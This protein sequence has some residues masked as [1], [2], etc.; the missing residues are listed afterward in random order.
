[1]SVSIKKLQLFEATARLGKLTKAASELALSQSA[2]SQALK[3]LEQSLGYAL[4]ERVG[5]DLLIT[6]NGLKSLPKVRQIAGLLDSIKLTNLN[7][8]SGTLR[9]VASA[10]IA[11]YL[12]PKLIAK[13]IKTYPEVAPEI[14]I[15]NTQMVIDYLDKGKA[16]IG[17]IEGPAVHKHLQIT[18]W[19]QD[20]LQIFCSTNHL[21]ANKAVINLEQL[22]QQSWVLR[23]QG[24]G[25]RAIF[26]TAIEQAG[27]HIN[28]GIELTRQDAIK[29][30]VKAGLGLG[31]L[32]Q[33]T[34]ADELK[35]GSLVA[36]T[37]PLNLSRRFAI[38]THKDSHHSLLTQTFIDDLQAVATSKNI[39]ERGV[40]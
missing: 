20:K 23:E 26:D 3:E 2:A 27:A 11:T 8:M 30:S 17:L 39:T 24:S 1:M 9:V 15:G 22:Q 37:S 19:Q 40:I 10:T 25:T 13:F 4:F 18:S 12:L 16:S 38:V 31:C 36:L 29:E 33:L 32:S 28:L 21:L 14:H 34:I 7:A 5:R 35:N 6:E